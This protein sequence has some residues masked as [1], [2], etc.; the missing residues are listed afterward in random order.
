MLRS[1]LSEMETTID[2]EFLILHILNYLPSDYDNI[3]ENLEE[4]VDSVIN[5]LGI[6]DFR[7][8]LSENFEK[9]ACERN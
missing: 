8:K 9:C 2:D 1:R 5:P 6:E 7:Q 3:V 4:R